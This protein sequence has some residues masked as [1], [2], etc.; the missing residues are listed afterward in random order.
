[1]GSSAANLC[2]WMQHHDTIRS[3]LLA[4]YAEGLA[5]SK[6]FRIQLEL[7]SGHTMAVYASAGCSI[8][9]RQWWHAM[10]LRSVIGSEVVSFQ[11]RS[12]GQAHTAV[13]L[14][15]PCQC[16]SFLLEGRGD[17]RGLPCLYITDQDLAALASQGGAVVG[18]MCQVPPQAV[19]S[20]VE[21]E[22]TIIAVAQCS[23]RPSGVDGNE[24]LFIPRA[25]GRP[26]DPQKLRPWLYEPSELES[27]ESACPALDD[28]WTC[29]ICFCANGGLDTDEAPA[30]CRLPC[31]HVF[32]STCVN[33]WLR[34]KPTCPVCRCSVPQFARPA[35]DFTMPERGAWAH[36]PSDVIARDVLADLHRQFPASTTDGLAPPPRGTRGRHEYQGNPGIFCCGPPPNRPVAGSARNSFEPLLPCARTRKNGSVA[37]LA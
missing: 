11:E 24:L 15:G 32:H 10:D 1:M 31:R 34:R 3:M 36:L 37:W 20:E 6:T 5:R 4:S 27:D 33:Q 35:M 28:S 26:A 7:S 23:A 14:C 8:D 16:V 19:P 2:A 12:N 9:N 30:F 29:S 21:R 25:H 22:A 17:L 18:S 13:Q